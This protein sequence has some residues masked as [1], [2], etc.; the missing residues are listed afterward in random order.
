MTIQ[1]LHNLYLQS[2]GV[3]TDTRIIKPNQ[4]YFALSGDNF[5][6]NTFASQ[7][8]KQGALKAII[9]QKEYEASQTILTKNTLQTLQELASYHRTYLDIPI[10]GLTGSNGKTTTKELINA[11]LS[12]KFITYATQGNFNNHIGVPLTLLAMT[13]KT[14]IGIVEMGANHQKEIEALCEIS[15]PNYGLI[16]NFGKAHLEG[17]GGIEGVIKGKSELYTYLQNNGGTVFVNDLDPIQI[18]KSKD[19]RKRKTFGSPQSNYPI[20]LEETNPTITIKANNTPIQSQLIGTYNFTNIGVS[21][22]IGSYFKLSNDAIKK[23]IES[24]LPKNNRSQRIQQEGYAIILDAYN[25]NPTSM[26]AALQNLQTQNTSNTIAFIGDMFEVGDTTLQEHQDI[27]QLAHSLGINQVIAIGPSFGASTPANE[28]QQLFENYDAFAEAYS[29]I[30]PS[31]SAILIKGSR[32]MKM[33]RIL[34]LLPEN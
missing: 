28:R 3:C 25:A 29:P 10:I 24:Y 19:I 4:L 31:N 20:T 2:D 12:Q 1:E 30:I 9:D 27:L 21:A 6:G 22:V 23:G 7:A 33:E 17:F 8:I 18:E 14:E 5:N 11:V 26:V 34:D 15:K 32:G 13:K 16:T